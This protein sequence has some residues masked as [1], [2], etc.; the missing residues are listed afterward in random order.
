MKEGPSESD[1]GA[2][3][4]IIGRG[5]TMAPMVH[6]IMLRICDYVTL[7]GKWEFAEVVPVKDLDVER[8]SW[9][10]HIDS[11][12]S[13]S[14]NMEEEGRKVGQMDPRW[15]LDPLLLILKIEERCHKP[16]DVTA[17]RSREWPHDSQEESRALSP[18]V[19]RNWILPATLMSRKWIPLE[20]PKKITAP[21]ITWF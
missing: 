5:R 1:I 13:L 10:I 3:V 18:T 17:S 2:N 15:G 19:T 16:R 12:L 9:M 7:H 11:M 20:P 4:S 8:L 14:L 21:L 6:T